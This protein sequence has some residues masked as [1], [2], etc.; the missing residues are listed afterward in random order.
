[1]ADSS[2]SW[3]LSRV[4]ARIGAA[5]AG[6]LAGWLLGRWLDFPALG[7]LGGGSVAVLALSVQDSLKGE[8][9]LDWLRAPE[10]DLRD[11]NGLWGE[12]SHGVRRLLQQKDL[13]AA[14]ERARLAEFLSAIQA[15]PNGV[16]L[17]NATEHIT[18]IS[19]MAAEHFG[20]NP[21]RDLQQRVTN[22]VRQPAF[23]QYLA[24]GDYREPVKCMLSSG[25]GHMMIQVRDYGEGLKLVLSQDITERELAD[26]MRRD[27]VANVSHEIRTPLTVLSGFIET[28]GSLP[29]T[30]VERKRVIGLMSQQAERMQS[31]VADL[32][33][34]ATIEGSP[35]P[36]SDRWW[37]VEKLMQRLQADGLALSRERHPIGLRLQDATGQGGAMQLSGVESEWLSAM[38]NLVSNAVRYT[39]EGQPIDICW[40]L[41]ADGSAE[42]SVK[43]GGIG[44]APEHIPRLTERFYRVDGSR[45]RETGGTGLG[46]S[47]VKHVVQRH[48][49]ELRVASEPGKGSTFTLTVPALRVRHQA[50]AVATA[51]SVS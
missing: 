45:S 27:F 48:G 22:L 7:A 35:R 10:T 42:F 51:D 31:L 3:L 16:M 30:D 37:D 19:D 13:E 47:I 14:T 6:G 12:V 9:L 1:M 26:N 21:E 36:P 28:M 18:W 25:R 33:T 38:G 24:A 41:L 40:S 5:T 20:L 8:A 17:L 11:M 34:L 4:G 23:V 49:G 15:S 29:L 43:D 44:I 2:N 46:L 39:P 50:V 32:L